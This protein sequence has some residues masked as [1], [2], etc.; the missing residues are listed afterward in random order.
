MPI[1][2]GMKV[3]PTIMGAEAAATAPMLMAR[4]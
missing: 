4:E 2:A 3:C 1:A